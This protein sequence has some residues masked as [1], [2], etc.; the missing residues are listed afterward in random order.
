MKTKK[1]L[2][3]LLISLVVI[4]SLLGIT[5]KPTSA[6]S[7]SGSD[8]VLSAKIDEILRNQGV[9]LGNLALMKEE[10]NIIKL[11]ITQAQ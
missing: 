7:A 3:G 2:L 8:A 5:E 6:Q 10:L 11:R 9:I 4:A 1:M